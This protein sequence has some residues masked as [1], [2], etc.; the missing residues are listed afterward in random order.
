MST[1]VSTLVAD[2]QEILLDKI[3]IRWPTT[4]LIEWINLGQLYIV[5]LKPS[6]NSTIA[7]VNL[8]EGP[9][10]TIPDDGISLIR[11]RRNTNGKHV[12]LVDFEFLSAYSPSWMLESPNSTVVEYMFNATEPK[13]F[14]VRPPQPISGPGSMEIVYSQIPTPVVQGGDISLAD[15]YKEPLL[16]YMLYRAFSKDADHVTNERRATDHYNKFLEGLGLKTYD[17]GGMV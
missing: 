4:E 7:V 14:Y 15:E 17:V 5:R 6:A 3:G 8:V 11:V 10:Q 12:R 13:N 2:A 1:P 16:D 9:V